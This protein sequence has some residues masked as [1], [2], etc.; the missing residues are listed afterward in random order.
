MKLYGLDS[1]VRLQCYSRASNRTGHTKCV[2]LTLAH[3][4]GKY[5]WRSRSVEILDLF[6][7]KYFFWNTTVCVNTLSIDQSIAFILDRFW[8]SRVDRTWLVFVLHRWSMVPLQTTFSSKFRTPESGIDVCND[9][10]LSERCCHLPTTTHSPVDT[11]CSFYG[12]SLFTYKVTNVLVCGWLVA[13][14]GSL[15]L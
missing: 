4:K 2:H 5:W 12:F 13:G 10:L 6:L 14:C 8:M 1:E 7:S 3:C 15:L 9:L 11:A